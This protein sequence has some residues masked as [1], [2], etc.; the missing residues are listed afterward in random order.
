[1]LV[2]PG[3]SLKSGG[4]VGGWGGRREKRAEGSALCQ[5]YFPSDFGFPITLVFCGLVSEGV[6]VLAKLKCFL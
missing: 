5:L 4:K 6:L 2:L 1:M 3:A